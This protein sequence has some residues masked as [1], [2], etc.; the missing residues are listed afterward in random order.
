MNPFQHRS[1]VAVA[2]AGEDEGLTATDAD[3]TDKTD[4]GLKTEDGGA[5]EAGGA[6]NSFD[7]G[8]VRFAAVCIQDGT[9][10]R[11]LECM[12]ELKA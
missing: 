11:G 3:W 7:E 12:Q 2:R 9:K 4:F 8:S 6:S 1:G 5:G 10:R